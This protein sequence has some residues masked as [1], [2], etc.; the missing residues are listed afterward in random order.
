MARQVHIKGR[1]LQLIQER[2][3]WDYEIA[4]R[5]AAEY[6]EA[7]GDYWHN[8]IRLNLADLYT[9]GLVTYEE[10]TLDSDKT[11]GI[12]KPVFRYALTAFGRDRMRQTGLELTGAEQGRVES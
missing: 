7:Q 10:A 4:A 9:G 8:T 6:S 11:G 2:S 12:E 3:Q 1:I 5:I